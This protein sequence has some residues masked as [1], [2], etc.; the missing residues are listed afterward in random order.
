VVAAAIGV[1]LFHEHL[2]PLN[3]AG[4]GVLLAAVLLHALRE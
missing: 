4:T 2:T 1:L 3:L